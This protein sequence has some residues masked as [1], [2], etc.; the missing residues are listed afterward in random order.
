MVEFLV[1]FRSTWLSR[2]RENCRLL[3]TGADDLYDLAEKLEMEH[4]HGPNFTQSST[5]NRK[6]R[7]KEEKGGESTTESKETAGKVG[8]LD[9]VKKVSKEKKKCST[10]LIL[11]CPEVGE[12]KESTAQAQLGYN[13]S[14]FSD[15]ILATKNK[16]LMG[17]KAKLK[18]SKPKPSLKQKKMHE[19]FQSSNQPTGISKTMKKSETNPKFV[20]KK[21]KADQH[22]AILSDLNHQRSSKR[23]KTIISDYYSNEKPL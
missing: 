6:I 12:G 13:F 19:F 5:T 11:E 17:K 8:R 7:W 23:V 2:R 10:E 20:N 21:R 14:N 22:P 3:S 18:F 15:L 9:E 16:N 4:V 1:E